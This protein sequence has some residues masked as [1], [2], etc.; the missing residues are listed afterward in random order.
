M[1]TDINVA[2]EWGKFW[3]GIILAVFGMGIVLFSLIA[4]PTGVIHASVITIF[5][6][7]LGF[8]G[9]IFGIDS[10]AKIR[11]HEQDVDFELKSEQ[12]KA[13]FE[14]RTRELDDK[15]R[16]FEKKLKRFEDEEEDEDLD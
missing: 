7:I 16:R 13:D 9:A 1:K 11:M 2:R 12:Q 15:M 3:L 10:N 4:P 14:L 6:S 5:G 8:V